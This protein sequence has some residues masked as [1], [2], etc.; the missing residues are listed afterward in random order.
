VSVPDRVYHLCTSGAL[1][2]ALEAGVY[3][4]ASL[5]TEGFIHCSQAYQVAPTAR[6][7]FARVPEVVVLEIDPA[8]LT[9]RLVYEAPAPLPSDAPKT[10]D[11]DARYP[12]CYGPINLDAIEDVLP[13]ARFV[14]SG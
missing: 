1:R 8:R 14:A 3:R 4:A 11:P 10:E 12:H 5:E 2:S 6:A 9:S 7:Y 13:L